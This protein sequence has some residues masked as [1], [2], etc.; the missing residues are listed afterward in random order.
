MGWTSILCYSVLP[1]GGGTWVQP[2][3]GLAILKDFSGKTSWAFPV[4][5]WDRDSVIQCFVCIW[6]YAM[7]ISIFITG[8]W[9]VRLWPSICRCEL[10]IRE[11]VTCPAGRLWHHCSYLLQPPTCTHVIPQF[12]LTLSCAVCPPWRHSTFP[13]NMNITIL[14]KLSVGAATSEGHLSVSMKIVNLHTQTHSNST[15]T[16]L[17]KYSQ[18]CTKSYIL[19]IFIEA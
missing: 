2:R 5:I 11:G 10:K 18:N 14:K 9:L 17:E 19:R 1:K 16:L 8:L 3:Y 6:P 15:S 13:L 4:F 12:K 7:S